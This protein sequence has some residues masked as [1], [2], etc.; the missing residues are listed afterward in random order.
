MLAMLCF[1]GMD[2]ISKFLVADYAVGQMMWIRYIL[3]FLFAWFIVRRQGLRQALK[4]RRPGLQLIRSLIAVVEGA[5]FVLAFRYLPLAD[6]HA[7]AA[8]SPLIVI[9]LGV[10]FL[11]ERAGP[12]RWLAVLAGFIGVMMIIRP[13]LRV[14]DWPV[15]LPLVGAVMWAG[16]QVLTRL[17]ARYDSPD[18]SLIWSILVALVVTTFV[19]PIDWQWPTATVWALM[20]IIAALGAVAHYALIKALDYAEA[21]AVQP[22]SYT[23]L[24]WATLLGVVIF[25]DVPDAWTILGAAIVV[26][27]GLYTWHHDRRTPAA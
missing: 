19:G 11:G 3:V 15:L 1:A 5:M 23:L 13:G 7:I 12:A 20:V 27:S 2:A 4:S 9:A 18:T 17:A 8:T 24:V 22:Y 6:T 10:I 16:Y 26:A 25:G 14:L 21:G